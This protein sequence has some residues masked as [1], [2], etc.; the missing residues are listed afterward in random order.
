V[1]APR[2]YHSPVRAER[3]RATRRR[4][5]GAAQAVFLSGGSKVELLKT[6]WDWAVVG[7]DEPVPMAERASVRRMQ[8][9]EDPGVLVRLW[10]QQVLDVAA[11]VGGLALTLSR[12]ADVDEEAAALLAGIDAERRAGATMFLRHLDDRAW[13]RPGLTVEHAADMC[14]MLMNPLLPRRLRDERGWTRDEVE[15]WLVRLASTSL[16]P[17]PGPP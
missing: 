6:A 1:G 11:R 9:E 8:A 12:A 2:T 14:W 5:V 16:L 4:V 7:D 13:L 15:E 10:V 3:A 17:D